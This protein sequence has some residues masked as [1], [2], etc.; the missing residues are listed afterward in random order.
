MRVSIFGLGYVGAVCT[1]CLAKVGHDIIGV[2]VVTDKVKMIQQGISP[3][4]EPGLGD[5]LAKGVAA[6]KIKATTSVTEAINETDLSFVAVPTPSLPN[7]SLDLTYIE[8]SCRQ[9]GEAIR[10]KKSF[11][12]IVIRSTVLP[13]SVRGTVLPVLEQATGKKAGE[14]F[15][16]AVNPEFLRES[17]AIN[18]FNNPA[19][20][21]VGCLDDVSAEQLKELYSHLDA[22]LFIKTIEVAEMVKYTCNAWHAVKVAFSNEIGTIAKAC[23]VDGRE[24]MDIFCTDTKLNISSYYMRP[25]FAFGGSCLPKDVRAL[26]HRASQL[27]IKHPLLSSVMESNSNHVENSFKLIENSGKRKVGFLGISF[28]AGT[29]DL[30]EAPQVTLV[31]RLLGKG[32]EIRVYDPNVSYAKVHGANKEYI[33]QRI[34][35]ITSLLHDD[36]D[37]VINDSDFIV[38]GNGNPEFSSVFEKIHDQHHVLDLNGFMHHKSTGNV[39]GICW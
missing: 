10:D 33:E 18:D 2:D 21:V 25:G 12:T 9:I 17:S 36:L 34:P 1:A 28:K 15:G 3:I 29:D 35:H 22:P 31:E 30:R 20:T 4:V 24:V 19:M 27:D 7:G 11:H 32:Y 13:G 39:Q 26:T 5:L 23:N 16:L 6:G 37:T 8:K 38:I 14:G